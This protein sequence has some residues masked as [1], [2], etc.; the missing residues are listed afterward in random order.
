MVL[1]RTI[2]REMADFITK[3]LP[4]VTQA[5]KPT[6][7]WSS[8]SSPTVAAGPL[9]TGAIVG[10][11]VSTATIVAFIAGVLAGVLLFYCVSKHQ[12]HQTSK[13]ETA[14]CQQQQAVASYNQLQQPGP[15]YAEVIK[16]RQN[17]AYEV[18]Q[19]AIEM[20]AN[21]SYQST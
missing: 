1:Y 13:P 9:T 12:S 19:T 2:G 18:T 7:L 10:I 14:S 16:L 20:R 3:Q 21:E 8:L 6:N 5:H 4:R 11:T 15:E 17:K